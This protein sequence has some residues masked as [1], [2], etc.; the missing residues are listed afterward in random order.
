MMSPAGIEQH[1]PDLRPLLLDD[2]PL[3]QEAVTAGRQQGW[4]YYFPFMFLVFWGAKNTRMLWTEDQGSI[5]VFISTGGKTSQL[6]LFAPPFPGNRAAL[7]RCLERANDHNGEHAANIVWIDEQDAGFVQD[8]GVLEMRPKHPEYLYR[9]ADLAAM[10]GP[11]YRSLRRNVSLVGRRADLETRS[12]TRDDA[13]QCQQL[14]ERW[15]RIQGQ[16]YAKVRGRRYTLGSLSLETELDWKTLRGIV[17]TISGRISGFAFGGEIRPGL[18]CTM[19]LKSDPEEPSLG[20]YLRQRFMAQMQDCEVVNDGSDLGAPGLRAMK[21][22]FRPCGMHA[23][24]RAQQSRRLPRMIATM[25]RQSDLAHFTAPEQRMPVFEPGPDDLVFLRRLE[26]AL[27][28]GAAGGHNSEEIDRLF[29]RTSFPRGFERLVLALYAPGQKRILVSRPVSEVTSVFFDVFSLLQAHPRCA[30]LAAQPFRL[31][32][33]FIVEP[34]APVD[35]YAVGM[36]RRGERHFEIG[37]DGLMFRGP[38]GKL[39]LFLP[40]D[41]YVRSIMGMGQLRDYLHRVHGEDYLRQA[42]CWSFRSQSYVSGGA[43]WLRL[44]RGIPLA[45]R[46]TKDRLEQVVDLAIAHIQR[47]QEKNGKFLYYYDSARDSRRD[48]EHPRRDPQKNPFYNILRHCGG[49][50]TCIFYEKCK[51]RGETLDAI[52]RAIDYLLAS[53]RTQ[54]YDGRPGAFIYSEKKAKLGGTGIALYLAAEYQLHTGD[55]RYQEW[56]DQLAWHLLHQVTPTGEFIYY[57]IYLDKPVAEKD[58][59]KYFS[60]YY[61]G[62]AVCGL[63]KYLHLIDPERRPPFFQ[64][65]RKALEFLLVV[66]PKT[67]AKEYTVVPSDSW[68]MM[69]ILELWDFPE[70][71]DAM[72]ADFVFA[73]ARKMIDQM[74][75]VTDAP[76]PDYA[77]S[78]YYTYGDYPYADGARCEGLLGAYQ[79]AVKMGERE[80]ARQIWPALRLAAWALLHL[81]NTEDAIYFARNPG[82]ALGGIRFKHTR[83]WF[84]IDTIQHVASFYAKMLPCWDE[85]EAEQP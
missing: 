25:A 62:E 6:Q 34:P 21:E 31:Q 5:C 44:Y 27:R 32:M 70:M 23:V 40:G 20:Y 42:Q 72:Y 9:S 73:D 14:F 83:Q 48:H 77:G 10:N 19:A 18:G 43:S 56:M 79:L 69:G 57:N 26:D 50:L 8:L 54:D 59:H 29:A 67:R 63:A 80:T 30:Q 4:A 51:G 45:G 75:K 35:F 24:F 82:M 60:F 36:S 11:Q 13:A 61:P 49:G 22:R 66:R 55:A 16:K 81:V 46:L 41:A 37:L 68:L 53:T 58:N 85:A 39:R 74:Y 3:F 76:Y 71:R 78:Y 17:V 38:D 7:R 15:E 28:S 52:R 47:T 84:R 65:L 12:Y 1:A 64:K 33:D 2:L